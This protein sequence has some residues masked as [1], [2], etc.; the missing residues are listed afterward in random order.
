MEFLMK[1]KAGIVEKHFIDPQT[2][3]VHKVNNV[4]NYAVRCEVKDKR[5]ARKERDTSYVGIHPLVET[6][7]GLL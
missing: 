7:E 3:T 4:L 1:N 5:K 6:L 2:G